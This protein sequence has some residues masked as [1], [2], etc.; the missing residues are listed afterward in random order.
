M[1]CAV[2]MHPVAGWPPLLGVWFWGEALWRVSA[3]RTP[4]MAI[5]PLIA[6]PTL[7]SEALQTPCLLPQLLAQSLAH[8]GCSLKPAGSTH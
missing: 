5:A 3:C 1:R 7:P 4:S 8:S 6:V 2:L